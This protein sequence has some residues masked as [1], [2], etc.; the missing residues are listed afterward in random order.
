MTS[1][2]KRRSIHLWVAAA[3]VA[4]MG[5]LAARASDI[6]YN[7]NTTITSANPTGNP[8]QSDSVVGTL[9]TDGTIGVLTPTDIVSWDLDLNDGLNSAN[10]FEL[11]TT[12]STLVEDTGSALSAT[13]TGLSFDFSGAGEFLI[14]AN[15]P[16]PFSGF[17]Y[18]C[19]STGGACLAGETIAPQEVFVDG[20]VATGDAAPVGNQPLDQTPP[21]GVTPE[22]GTFGLMLTGLLGL[23]GTVR[24]KLSS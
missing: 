21:T 7:I 10:D 16:G 18:F 1:T 19:F 8:L 24:R 6:V 3:I 11:T 20:V 9:T 17:S 2:Q 15:N 22:P 13:A 4:Q 5:G 12:D 14:Q 23:S